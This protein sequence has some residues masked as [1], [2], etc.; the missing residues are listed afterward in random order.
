[1]S[2]YKLIC[3]TVATSVTDQNDP[4]QVHNQITHI[5]RHKSSAIT[6]SYK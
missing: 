3:Y 1:M 6:Q 4:N 5:N 2:C